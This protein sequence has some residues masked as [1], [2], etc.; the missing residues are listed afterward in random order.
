[1][2]KP[3]LRKFAPV[4]LYLS[5]IAAL[6]SLGLYIVQRE[7]N[8]PL[9]ISLGLV[10]AGLAIFAI[11][12]PE[13][14]RVAL[15][16]RQAK[17]GSNALIMSLAFLGILVVV[18]YLVYNNS[19]RWDLTEDQQ[20]TLAP[21]TRETLE[22]LPQ[23]VTAL[24]FYTPRLSSTFAEGLLDQYKFHSGGNFDYQFI[25][26]E[27]DP[28]T[29]QQANITRDGTIVF[30][31][32]EYQE[33]VTLVSEREMTAALVRLISPG[34][35]A[36]YFLTGHGEY[37]PDEFGE[38]SYSSVKRALETKNYRVET[39]NLLALNRIP[40]DASVIVIAGPTRP[41]SEG[42]VA[43]LRE[44]LDGGGALVV[45]AEPLPMTD[46]GDDP[47]PLADYLEE[48]WG[49]VL[50]KDMVVDLTSN[51]VYIAVA[52]QYGDHLITQRLQGLVT[53]FPTARSVT[54]DRTVEEVDSD[55]LVFTAPQSWAET[56]LNALMGTAE[57]GESPQ[58]APDEDVDIIG[59]V[60]LSAAAENYINEGRL[61]VFGDSD[62][63]SDAFFNQYGNGDLLV[64]AIDWAAEQEDIINLTPR[65]SVTRL[66]VPPQ[67][68][69]LN[70]ILLGSVFIVPGAVLAAGVLAWVQRR[71]RG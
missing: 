68:Y 31:M 6:A 35:Q 57:A 8:L 40:E 22:R 32:G 14:V 51:Q 24:A 27:A 11:L 36:V 34:E 44:F 62:F 61:V 43:L 37:S 58:I 56:D 59:P 10:V 66:L 18:N 70:L 42:E 30:R 48:A 50:G 12:N 4:G 64:N 23:N 7:F 5:L 67:Q 16:G 38:Q 3:G 1:M 60:P 47:D 65:D 45:L 52:N 19:Q 71:R 49:I 69:V 2:I 53:I 15:T 63:A 28:L 33:Q 20:F 39:L 54:V 17:Y 9:Q 21:E 26:P 13:Q 29:A 46:F 25:N 41:I 55:E